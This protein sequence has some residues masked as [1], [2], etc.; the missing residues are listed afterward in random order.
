MN[1]ANILKRIDEMSAML[2]DSF[3]IKLEHKSE[4]FSNSNKHSSQNR[5]NA[6]LD[7]GISKSRAELFTRQNDNSSIIEVTPK[8]PCF[9][10]NVL[11]EVA[12]IGRISYYFFYCKDFRALYNTK[13]SEL[14]VITDDSELYFEN[15]CFFIKEPGNAKPRKFF[16]KSKY[17]IIHVVITGLY[18]TTL[19]PFFL[20]LVANDKQCP[21]IHRK[22]D[23][24]FTNH[25]TLSFLFKTIYTDYFLVLFQHIPTDKLPNNVIDAWVLAALPRLGSILPSL[26]DTFYSKIDILE[27][28]VTGEEFIFRIFISLLFQTE[29]FV[30]YIRSL[31]PKNQS[32]KANSTSSDEETYINCDEL[33]I[34]PAAQMFLFFAAAE[35]EK[36]SKNK[37][38]GLNFILEVLY[39]CGVE[40]V[41]KSMS[42][43]SK[44]PIF[45]LDDIDTLNHLKKYLRQP[46]NYSP[47]D[48]KDSHTHFAKLL[49]FVIE[50][51]IDFLSLVRRIEKQETV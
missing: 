24:S 48:F 44:H 46:K 21:L 47:H 7:S 31:I 18:P 40:P 27:Y 42:S 37:T 28:K 41:V 43:V 8:T 35:W 14:E 30:S 29:G 34:P 13:S 26:F 20:S 36:R 32:D 5:S 12:K 17:E 15:K 51:S 19:E 50:G 25:L 38:L 1:E 3:N 45:D 4:S 33:I 10:I 9:Y 22:A 2:H 23:L 16:I 49:Q 39:K 6:F 11:P